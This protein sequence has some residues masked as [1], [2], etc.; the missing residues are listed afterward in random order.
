[1]EEAA[2][3]LSMSRSAAYRAVKR[4]EIRTFRLNG[5]IKVPTA[6]LLEMLGR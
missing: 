4:G 5:K 2:E 6:P 3:L 1:M